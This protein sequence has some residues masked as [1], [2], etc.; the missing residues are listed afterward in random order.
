MYCHV[1]GC[2][3]QKQEIVSSMQDIIGHCVAHE[4]GQIKGISEDFREK[5]I[6]KEA[7]AIQ[8]QIKSN[9]Q[10]LENP[11]SCQM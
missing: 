6:G 1:R 9:L 11:S 8:R 7:G 3:I 4:Q 2:L 5:L 10:S